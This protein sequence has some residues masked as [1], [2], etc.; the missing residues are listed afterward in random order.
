ML[1]DNKIT[2]TNDADFDVE[3]LEAYLRQQPNYYFIFR[4]NPFINVYNWQNGNNGPWDKFVKKIGVEPVVYESAKVAESIENI[5]NR[6][7]YLGYYGSKVET[8][9]KLKKKRVFVHYDVTLGKRFPIK[10]IILTLP[11]R[12]TFAS[13][14]LA[15]TSATLI[16][17]GDYLSEDILEK[18]T[19]RATAV[20]NRIGYYDFNKHH[21]FFEADTLSIPDAAIL[22]MDIREYTRNETP[23]ESTPIRKFFFK[24]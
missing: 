18:E 11:E 12:G 23:D 20:M 6:L 21:F 14:Y 2:V 10:D 13:D 4:W 19:V 1:A 16:R 15:D 3:S 9:L 22:K 24:H 8:T 17:P 7:E 5:S